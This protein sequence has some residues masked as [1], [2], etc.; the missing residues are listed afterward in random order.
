MRYN[1][2]RAVG[3]ALVASK[4]HY[5][6]TS[7]AFDAQTILSSTQARPNQRNEPYVTLPIRYMLIAIWSRLGD[8][9]G[10]ARRLITRS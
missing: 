1:T 9:R 5:D 4:V 2:R 6:A 7:L 3:R 10:G 8:Q